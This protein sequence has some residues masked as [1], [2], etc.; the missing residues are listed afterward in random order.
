MEQQNN[1]STDKCT[2]TKSIKSLE[3]EIKELKLQLNALNNEIKTIRK[4][5]KGRGA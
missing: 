5:F 2:C 4:A 1:K 3:K